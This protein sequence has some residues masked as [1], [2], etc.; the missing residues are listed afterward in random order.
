MSEKLSNKKIP[1]FMHIP[2]NAGTYVLSVM[3]AMFRYYHIEKGFN[4]K[5]NWNLSLRKFYIED[6]NKKQYATL[7]VYDPDNNRN[8]NDRIK[9]HPRSSF[10][11]V[12][13][14]DDIDE[15]L[16]DFKNKKFNLFA[17]V[18]EP[19]GVKLIKDSFFEN[20]FEK[21]DIIPLY[22][23]VFRKPYERAVSLFNYIK[24]QRSIHEPTHNS[25][26]ADTFEEYLKSSQLEKS[27]IIRNLASVRDGADMSEKDFKTACDILENFKIADIAKTDNL[28]DDVFTECYGVTRHIIKDDKDFNKNAT[29]KH[30]KK[31]FNEL[32]D[33]LK[34]LFLERTKF[35][36]RLYDYFIR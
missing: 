3:E 22:Y 5:P 23:T 16:K 21:A 10:I 31:R 7:F 34:Q 17:L 14:I 35:D 9:P 29:E 4:N 2:K 6:H 36:N 18:I 32:D 25:I 13:N 15:V 28:I 30:I 27:W 19:R 24:G 20:I 12:I 11:S 33:E 26:I 1:I 8:I